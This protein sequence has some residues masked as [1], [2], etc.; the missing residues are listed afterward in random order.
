MKLYNTRVKQWWRF[1]RKVPADSHI[2]GKLVQWV[3]RKRGFKM[4]ND[5]TT[6]SETIAARYL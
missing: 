6:K 2:S 3:A 1:A 5:Y 4:Y